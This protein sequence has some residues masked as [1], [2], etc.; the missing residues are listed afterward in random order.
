MS[1]QIHLDPSERSQI[2]GRLLFYIYEIENR[3]LPLY[4]NLDREQQNFRKEEIERLTTSNFA[5]GVVDKIELEADE[6]SNNY[7]FALLKIKQQLFLSLLAAMFH[8][9]DKKL[10]ELIEQQLKFRAVPEDVD[11]FVWKATFHQLVELFELFNWPVK[12]E[13]FFAMLQDISSIVN[14]YKHGK[15]ASFKKLKKDRPQYF[16]R[17]YDPL[18]HPTPIK[19][20]GHD[21]LEISE[22]QLKSLCECIR[23]FWQ[24]FPWQVNFSGTEIRLGKD[25]YKLRS[26]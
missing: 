22:T 18:N 24:Q 23:D 16:Y 19:D 5:E 9:W 25:T 26:L 3:V 21:D 20:I 11:K 8:D 15:G 2:I 4:S 13:P 14:V 12:N 6:Q 7:F 1:H 10:R 17:G